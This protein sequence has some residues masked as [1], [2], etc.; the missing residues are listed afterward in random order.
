MQRPFTAVY[1]L[2]LKNAW[3]IFLLSLVF[4]VVFHNKI[5]ALNGEGFKIWAVYFLLRATNKQPSLIQTT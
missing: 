5:K 4:N 1:A 3:I 2:T